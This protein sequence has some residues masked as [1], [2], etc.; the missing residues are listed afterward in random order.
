MSVYSVSACTRA[1]RGVGIA[2]ECA[3]DNDND[4][5]VVVPKKKR[6]EG[7]ENIYPSRSN[8]CDQ[9]VEPAHC[10]AGPE[11]G[12]QRSKTVFLD[13]AASFRYVGVGKK[14]ALRC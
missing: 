1:A 6:N 12:V 13:A 5:S 14:R 9:L 11:R 3:G 4:E 2:V 8:H 7:Q 10:C